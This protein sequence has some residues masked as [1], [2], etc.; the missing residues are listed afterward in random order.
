MVFNYIMIKYV[1]ELTIL[2]INMI[3]PISILTENRIGNSTEVK[4]TK[5]QTRIKE[6]LLDV[7]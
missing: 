4:C 6:N 7:Y 3:I 5:G 1:L 2:I